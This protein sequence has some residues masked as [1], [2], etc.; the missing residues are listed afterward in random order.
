MNKNVKYLLTVIGV[1][2]ALTL[3]IYAGAAFVNMELNPSF[4]AKNVRGLCLFL[5][6]G[7]LCVIPIIVKTK[8]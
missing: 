3:F 5:S 2:V 1:W 7:G 4:W 8:D 6:S